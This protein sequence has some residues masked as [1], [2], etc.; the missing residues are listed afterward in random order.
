MTSESEI[1]LQCALVSQKRLLYSRSDS[2]GFCL[3]AGSSYLLPSFFARTLEVS[4]ERLLQG[5]PAVD[6]VRREA[7]QPCQGC[8]IHDNWEV[9]PPAA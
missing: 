9:E 3:M 5:V 8:L 2:S 4:N 7:L 6:G 1:C